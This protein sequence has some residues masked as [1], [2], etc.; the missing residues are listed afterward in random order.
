MRTSLPCQAQRIRFGQSRSTCRRS[1]TTSRRPG[2][3]RPTPSSS[4]SK[5]DIVALQ[6]TH[7]TVLEMQQLANRALVSHSCYFSPLANSSGGV[8]IFV[9][10]KFYA[11]FRS[12][13]CEVLAV[14]RAIRLGK[15]LRRR[16]SPSVTNVHNETLSPQQTVVATASINGTANYIR[17]RSGACDITL[18]LGDWNFP[19]NGEAHAW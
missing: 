19:A 10:N 15:A 12:I 14:G 1:S 7:G 8:M 13:S 6:E 9:S 4:C 16:P 5:T 18:V 3:A 11:S 17:L 2:S